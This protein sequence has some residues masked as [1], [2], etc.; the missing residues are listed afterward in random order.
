MGPTLT[1]AAVAAGIVIIFGTSW[2]YEAHADSVGGNE[3][4]Q[5]H[6]HFSVPRPGDLSKAD[7]L[8]LY[9]SIFD[10]MVLGY[11]KSEDPTGITF[12][13]W[14]RYNDAP[15]R[16]KTH[17]NRYVNNYANAIAKDAGYGQQIEGQVMPA[18]AILAKDSF[19]YTGAADVFAGALFIMEKLPSGTSPDT[20]DWR[21]A[22]IMPDGSI[23]GDSRDTP[24]KVAFCHECHTAQAE[25]DHL[26]FLP[27]AYRR[28]F[29]AD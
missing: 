24:E 15:Y 6:R 25:T 7:A 20:A 28:E 11:G 13:L 18:G 22:M 16:S 12:H 1:R 17:G 21:Y 9:N 3:A 26:F 23:F 5:P 14:R 4:V 19:T 29:L 8:I 10:A 27:E 2:P